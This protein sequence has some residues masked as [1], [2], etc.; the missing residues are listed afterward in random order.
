MAET[1]RRTNHAKAEGKGMSSVSRS[2]ILMEVGNESIEEDFIFV[3][4][5][6][7]T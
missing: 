3:A 7:G 6:D 1:G 4:D 5:S 2:D